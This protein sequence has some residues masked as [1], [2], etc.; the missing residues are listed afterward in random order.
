[1]RKGKEGRQHFFNLLELI[2]KIDLLRDDYCDEYD[3]EIGYNELIHKICNNEITGNYAT[4][5]EI[6]QID[7]E[8]NLLKDLPILCVYLYIYNYIDKIPALIRLIHPDSEPVDQ[9]FVKTWEALEAI[10]ARNDLLEKLQDIF[11]GYKSFEGQSLLDDFKRI[12]EFW[13]TSN[14]ASQKNA[15]GLFSVG[16]YNATELQIYFKCIQSAIDQSPGN[17]KKVQFLTST[18]S[19][20]I[21]FGYDSEDRKWYIVDSIR[22][23]SSNI[24]TGLNENEIAERI[25]KY[26]SNEICAGFSSIIFTNKEVHDHIKTILAKDENWNRINDFN[27]DELPYIFRDIYLSRS[28]IEFAID[29]DDAATV[30]KVIEC[31]YFPDLFKNNSYAARLMM[32]Y[33]LDKKNIEIIKN[34]YFTLDNDQIFYDTI[35]QALE[36]LIKTASQTDLQFLKDSVDLIYEIFTTAVITGKFDTA[37]FFIS[38]ELVDINYT[39]TDGTS[40]LM[41]ACNNNCTKLV[42]LLLSK[43]ANFDLKNKKNIDVLKLAYLNERKET[44]KKLL[45]KSTVDNLSEEFQFNLVNMAIMENDNNMLE[46]LLS[47]GVKTNMVN[48]SGDTPLILA[49]MHDRYDLVETL[50]KYNAD[51]TIVNNTGKIALTATQDFDIKIMITEYKFRKQSVSSL[52]KLSLLASNLRTD[53]QPVEKQGQLDMNHPF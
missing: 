7:P 40:M 13:C 48:K 3:T 25:C 49:C 21:S 9:N 15:L 35:I 53:S 24:I 2:Q 33:A 19:H 6:K 8:H 44:L 34:I 4:L 28:L 50:L 43:G 32:K 47:K 51:T 17:T 16:M 27:R 37:E 45:A 41:W 23:K 1:M 36:D 11:P 42:D 5:S 38:N 10:G 30:E 26:H 22:L 14:N 46:L 52:P 39:D 12:H 31:K 20:A 18:P 29:S